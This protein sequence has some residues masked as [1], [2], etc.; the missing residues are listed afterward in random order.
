MAINITEGHCND[1]DDKIKQAYWSCLAF[2]LH[3]EIQKNGTSFI[4]DNK[5]LTTRLEDLLITQD[6]Y[7]TDAYWLWRD[8]LDILDVIAP[9]DQDWIDE[10]YTQ[11]EE[12]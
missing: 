12:I 4:Q 10:I 3:K 11:E 8:L 1:C 2:L 5:K 7:R 9:E 6:R